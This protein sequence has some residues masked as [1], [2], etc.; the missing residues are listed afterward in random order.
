MHLHAVALNIKDYWRMSVQDSHAQTC[1]SSQPSTLSS[2]VVKACSRPGGRAPDVAVAVGGY[3]ELGA[4]N[5]LTRVGAS[6][7]H[8]RAALGVQ[9]TPPDPRAAHI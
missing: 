6:L 9:G 4:Q 7:L 8:D 5:A 1:P 3:S 2:W